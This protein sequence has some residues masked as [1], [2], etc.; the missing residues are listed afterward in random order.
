MSNRILILGASGFIGNSLYKELMPYFDVYGTYCHDDAAMKHNQVFF[1]FDIE[2]DSVLA[3]LEKIKPNV[4]ISS[5]RGRYEY[6]LKV[7]NEII[8]YVLSQND[9]RL[10]FLS[11]VNVFDGK[12]TFPSYEDSLTLAESDY[13]KYKISVEKAIKTLPVE[14]YAI[15]RLPMVLGVNAPAIFQLKQAIKHQASFEVYPN[16]IISITTANKIAQQ[17]HYIINKKLSGT[18]HLTSKDMVHHED[19]FRELTGKLSDKSPIFK[20]VFSSNDDSYLAILSKLN[21][22][23]KEYR[24]TVAEVIADSTLKEEISTLKT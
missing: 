13:G 3:V 7:H 19:L 15:L 20:S 8:N 17:V 1:Q 6:Q 10:L 5:L 14:K 2:K 24:I 18:F 4:V 22:L 11:S 12:N 23:P 16:L 9:C 21:K